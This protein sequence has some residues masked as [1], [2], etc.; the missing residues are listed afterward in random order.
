MI[1]CHLNERQHVLIINIKPVKRKIRFQSTAD[2]CIYA[3]DA[4]NC[5]KRQPSQETYVGQHAL[6]ERLKRRFLPHMTPNQ[7]KVSGILIK[8]LQLESRCCTQQQIVWNTLISSPS[9]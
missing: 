5:Y 8:I 4:I 9:T 2:T 3:K 1:T 7:K 6:A